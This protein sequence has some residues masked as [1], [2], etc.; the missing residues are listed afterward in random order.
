MSPLFS[1]IQLGPLRLSNRIVIAPMCQYSAEEGSA[2]DWHMIHLGGLAL[3]GAGLL[4]IEAT[5]VSP[6]GRISPDDLGLWSEANEAAL[7]KVLDS[8]R[9]YSPIPV[10]IQLAHAGR[11]AST[12]APWDGGKFIQQEQGGWLTLAPSALPYDAHDTPPLAL[13]ES[14]LQLIINQFATAAKRAERLGLEAIEVHAAHGYLLHQFLSP[15]ANNRDDG[16][17]GSLENRMRFPLAVFDAVRAAVGAEFPVGIRISATDWVEGGWDIEQSLVFA[18]E[19]EKRACAYIHVSSGGLSPLQSIPVEMNYQV[20]FAERIKK[21]TNLPVIAV[22]LIKE[23]KQAEA[24]IAQEQA[25]MVALAR[26]MLFDPRW[27]WHA[28]AELGG[29]VFAPKQYRR[30]QPHQFA[31][32]F[33]WVDQTGKK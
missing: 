1:P 27:P 30:S 21:E 32:L 5:A 10:A 8:V 2:T 13:D 6:E 14:G 11:K 26:G 3:S 16:Y 25:D 28:A 24:I 22:G 19:L 17:G 33:D 31:H 15:L 23:P 9:R 20:L 18:K 29:Q 4:I 7:K 12:Q